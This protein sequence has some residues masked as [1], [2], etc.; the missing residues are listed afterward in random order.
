M[1]QKF[2]ICKISYQLFGSM[3]LHIIVYC[4]FCEVITKKT[5]NKYEWWKCCKHGF[6][7][8]KQLL[9]HMLWEMHFVKQK[10]HWK[11]QQQQDSL[12]ICEVTRKYT[13]TQTL[14]DG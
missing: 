2:D 11:P 6:K 5:Q 8:C 10:M 1:A 3:Y 7:M 14:L 13:F 9:V 4:F 12:E